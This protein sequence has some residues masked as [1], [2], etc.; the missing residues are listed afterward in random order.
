[1]EN[2]I[3]YLESEIS[4]PVVEMFGLNLTALAWEE[5]RK[6]KDYLVDCDDG[7]RYYIQSKGMRPDT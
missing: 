2:L 5:K 6:F 4:R 1:M 7:W 3:E